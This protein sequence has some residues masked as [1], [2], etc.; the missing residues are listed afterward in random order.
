MNGNGW[1]CDQCKKTVLQPGTSAMRNPTMPEGW[2]ALIG[3]HSGADA[4]AETVAHY[5]ALPC[6]MKAVLPA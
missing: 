3:P 4:A 1:Q 5:C 6:V 2:Y